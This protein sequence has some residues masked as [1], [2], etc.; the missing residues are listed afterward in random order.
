METSV[1][2]ASRILRSFRPIINE[3]AASTGRFPV[4]QNSADFSISFFY[5]FS[6]GYTH[7]PIQ[8]FEASGTWKYLK[9]WMRELV[10]PM[11]HLYIVISFLVELYQCNTRYS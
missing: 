6:F 7:R 9:I 11:H 1:V 10:R 4:I 2:S 3:N 8:N 5:T